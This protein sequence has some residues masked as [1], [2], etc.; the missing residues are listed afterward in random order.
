MILKT[1]PVN[2]N[3]LDVYPDAKS[4]P[5]FTCIKCNGKVTWTICDMCIECFRFMNGSVKNE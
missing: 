1:D 4:E 5:E 3:Y 2:V